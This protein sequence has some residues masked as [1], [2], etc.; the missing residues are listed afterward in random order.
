MIEIGTMPIST[1]ALYK[2]R[3]FLTKK[4]KENKEG[5]VSEIDYH[6]ANREP[7]TGSIRLDVRLYWPDKRRHDLDNIKSL[8]DSCT[9]IL[10]EDDSQINELHL[11]KGYDKK[12]PRVEIDIE[13]L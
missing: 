12:N 6:W 4:G 9:G 2:G 10:Y 5:M 11:Y 7:F 13:E 8:L 3:K 1:N